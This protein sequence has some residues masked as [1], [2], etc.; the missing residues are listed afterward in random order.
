MTTKDDDDETAVGWYLRI[1]VKLN[2]TKPL[3]RGITVFV[4]EK[5]DKP[6]WCLVEYEFLPDFCSICGLIGHVDKSC[7][8]QLENGENP[9]F[10]KSLRC[11][12]NRKRG[13]DLIRERT[14]GGRIS[15][16]GGRGK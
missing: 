2:I 16:H 6:L 12:P 11:F 5:E 3:M 14:G 9:Q 7:G 4:G 1:K 13:A 8:V 15:C 10:S